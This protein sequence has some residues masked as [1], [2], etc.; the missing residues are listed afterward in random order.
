MVPALLTLLLHAGELPRPT[1]TAPYL[2][3]P[4]LEKPFKTRDW[5]PLAQ[6]APLAGGH[7]AFGSSDA[8]NRAQ[9]LAVPPS[10]KPVHF[11]AATL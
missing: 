5:P 9:M 2:P 6:A 10:L 1:G 4:R 8:N 7:G 11:L 3:L